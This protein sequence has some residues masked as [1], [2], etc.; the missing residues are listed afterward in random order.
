[1]S[2]E[3]AS[4]HLRLSFSAKLQRSMSLLQPEGLPPPIIKAI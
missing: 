4:Q 1:M 2:E 3:D